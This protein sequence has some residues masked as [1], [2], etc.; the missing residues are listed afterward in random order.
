MT[1]P[2]LDEWL[3]RLTRPSPAKHAKGQLRDL[4][5]NSRKTLQQLAQH[6]HD[7]ETAHI[8]YHQQQREA[9]IMQ[10]G[11][12]PPPA[13]CTVC[14]KPLPGPPVNFWTE[15]IVLKCGWAILVAVLVL[16]LSQVIEWWALAVFP[17]GWLVSLSFFWTITVP[18]L[19]LLPLLFL[20]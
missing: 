3:E 15:N 11:K 14:N 6:P 19:L 17:V 7:N 10:R 16:I 1:E 5:A 18:I 13:H 9:Q 20:L 12:K 4:A 8:L 2:I